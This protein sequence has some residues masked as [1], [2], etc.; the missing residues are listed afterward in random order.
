VF[1]LEASTGNLI[2]NYTTGREVWGAPAIA[3]GIAYVGSGDKNMYAFNASTGDK[4]WNYTLGGGIHASPAI[5]DGVVYVSS[6]DRYLYALNASTGTLMWKYLTISP[7]DINA[8]YND[9]FSSP[10]VANGCVYIAT[11]EGNV[12]AF[13]NNLNVAYSHAPLPTVPELTLPAIL[14]LMVTILVT[15]YLLKSYKGTIKGHCVFI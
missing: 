9:M 3:Y 2:W 1:A 6:D 8:T 5:A 4:I 15:I 13:G 7:S 14:L 11:T 10:I 12:L